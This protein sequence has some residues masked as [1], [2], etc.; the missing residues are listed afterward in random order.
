MVQGVV[1]GVGL[2]VAGTPPALLV[3]GSQVAAYRPAEAAEMVVAVRE[4]VGVVVVG[5]GRAL[6]IVHSRIL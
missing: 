1:Q 5:G 4:E 6:L 2:E 3:V